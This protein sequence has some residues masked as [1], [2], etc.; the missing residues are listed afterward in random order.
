MGE[1]TRE[2]E[3]V[4]ASVNGLLNNP[5]LLVEVHNEQIFRRRTR[6]D[7]L[8]NNVTK[9]QEQARRYQALAQQQRA[10]FLQSER[11]AL[12][13]GPEAVNKHPAGIVVLVP[14]PP[15]MN[16]EK[17]ESWDVG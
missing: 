16:D 9:S 14:Q 1:R 10:F 12:S 3:T 6:V 5:S 8:A 13:G 11:V 7:Q 2:A 15:T 4:T 17:L